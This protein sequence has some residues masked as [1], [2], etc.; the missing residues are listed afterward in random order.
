MIYIPIGRRSQWCRLR[1]WRDG[2]STVRYPRS[3][4]FTYEPKRVP[5]SRT[6]WPRPRHL[7]RP[8]PRPRLQPLAA[9]LKPNLAI[10]TRHVTIARIAR[11]VAT[12]TVGVPAPRSVFSP[13]IPRTSS[14]GHGAIG[15]G[16]RGER[17][18]PNRARPGRNVVSC[19]FSAPHSAFPPDRL[20]LPGTRSA[21][22]QKCRF[23]RC[24]TRIDTR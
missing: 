8:P 12:C 14:N 20:D 17:G 19:L 23:C 3:S 4:S 11:C 1:S 24:P 2:N 13:T 22:T 15:A 21:W 7:L 5:R 10:L 9:A 18:W 16:E 6:V